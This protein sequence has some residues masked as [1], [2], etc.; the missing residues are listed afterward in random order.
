MSEFRPSRRQVLGWG[1]LATA[2]VGT[3][4]FGLADL[5][6]AAA[7]SRRARTT[8]TDL[9]PAVRQ[10]AL[11][12]GVVLGDTFYIG[13]RNVEPA[14]LIAF[15]LPTGKVTAR[16]DLGTG[17]SVQA[18]AVDPT[19]RYLYAGV[20]QKSGG[21]QDNLY[22]WDLSRLDQ[23]A[24][25]IGRIADRDV[26]DV[27]VAPDGVLYAVGGG[28]STAP[29]LWQYDPATGEVTNCG[30][31]DPTST[32]ASAVAATATTVFFG[33]GSTLGGGG[34][35]GRATL[36]AYDRSARTF[37]SVIPTE[38]T[39][40]PSMRDLA[41]IGDPLVAGSAGATEN[42]KMA[43]MDLADLGSTGWPRSRARSPR[44]TPPT[45]TPSTT[46]RRAG[47]T[48]SRCPRQRCGP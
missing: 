37:T 26:R 14:R 6:T 3:G 16:T 19:G 2:A 40:D 36:F 7:D 22:R 43:I 11:M 48:R 1:A 47:S 46:P 20:L 31:P 8:I 4:G 23:P 33:G 27:A 10:F 9:G 21:P 13:S 24:K 44:C 28:S 5:P 30:I 34:S 32:L 39:A 25:A 45:A 41:V 42:A 17:Y 18:M 35:A 15:D 29:A 12:S 38:M